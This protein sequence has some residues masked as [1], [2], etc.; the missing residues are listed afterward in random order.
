MNKSVLF[1]IIKKH[2]FS[3]NYKT[4]N[5]LY[6]P[7]IGTQAIS[8]YNH[9]CNEA[10]KIID[11]TITYHEL[12]YLFN[13]FKITYNDFTK[14]RSLLEAFNLLETYY[15][16][17]KQCYWF[18]LNEP[19]SFK[20]FIDNQKFRHLLIKNIS[21]FQYE[22]LEYIYNNDRLPSKLLNVTSQFNQVFNEKEI[23]D[24]FE[25]NF[26]E[27]YANI[28]K[29]SHQS[30]VLNTE[31][32]SL[33]SFYFCNYNLNINE[34]EHCVYEA[35]VNQDNMFIVDYDLLQ[36]SFKKYINSFKNIDIF[37][38]AKINR[39]AKIFYESLDQ[40]D[41]LQVYNSYNNL[42]SEQYYYAIKKTSLDDTELAIIKNLKE[43]YRLSDPIINIMID[44][45]LLKTK[46][47]LNAKY[48]YKMAKSVNGCNLQNISDML[49][50]LR[51]QFN[52]SNRYD[53]ANLSLNNSSK[54]IHVFDIGEE[55]NK[56]W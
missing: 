34:I 30:I 14:L 38:K 39:N 11:S 2:D 41:F 10:D 17:D 45:S 53:E 22:R 36:I 33:I 37:T 20:K 46:G 44:F 13:P 32:K 49:K 35:I 55:K 31:V 28:S 23:N 8:L 4:L 27:L 3:P 7:I 54:E 16:V 43:V 47:I 21:Q 24:V 52:L 9:L 19:L 5:D 50:Y 40:Y 1:S 18:K 25:F 15:D 48:L 56:S 26:N 12:Q 42:N 6:L 51:H 29:N